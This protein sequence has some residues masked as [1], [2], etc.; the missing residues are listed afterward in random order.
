MQIVCGNCGQQI[1]LEETGHAASVRCPSCSHE[2]PLSGSHANGIDENA[3]FAS[4]ARRLLSETIPIE[5]D[6]CSL[7]L[8]VTKKMAGRRIR[9][10]GCGYMITVPTE[11]LDPEAFEKTQ[12]SAA[13]QGELAAIAQAASST[14]EKSAAQHPPHPHKPYKKPGMG[15][16]PWLMLLLAA[17]LVGGIVYG[18]H[19]MKDKKI[20]ISNPYPESTENSAQQTGV[21]ATPT[22]KA[23][24]EILSS[25]W[26]IF[27]NPAGYF[28]AAPGR[29]YACVELEAVTG[30]DALA[31][32]FDGSCAFIE[33]SGV[34]YYAAGTEINASAVIPAD[35][36]RKTL[37]IPQNTTKTFRLLFELPAAEIRG[38]L[39]IKG[40]NDLLVNLPKPNIYVEKL[41][42]D[43]IEQLPRNLKPMLK[44]PIMREFQLQNG[45]TISITQVNEKLFS[46]K[47]PQSQISGTAELQNDRTFRMSLEHS[48]LGRLSCRAILDSNG[49]LILYLSDKPMHQLTFRRHSRE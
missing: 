41:Q 31:I 46:V 43:Y 8:K 42:G 26:R 30:N 44:D 23:S 49:L 40:C 14:A 45:Q 37:K 38:R 3:G 6:S 2:I 39:D 35:V 12:S 11:I 16:M 24:L 13:A 5:C 19:V 22:S 25:G 9:C 10:P 17:G 4:R 34:R 7:C 15:V 29:L 27:A 36:D 18:L 32:P 48:L 47:F 20:K 21:S 1:E 28:P 33:A